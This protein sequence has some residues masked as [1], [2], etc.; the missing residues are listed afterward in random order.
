MDDGMIHNPAEVLELF[1]RYAELEGMCRRKD[2]SIAERDSRIAYLNTAL[3]AALDAPPRRM[4]NE[5]LRDSIRELHAM[6][7]R[8]QE[9]LKAAAVAATPPPMTEAD[10]A[11]VLAC[12]FAAADNNVSLEQ[13]GINLEALFECLGI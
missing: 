1:E 7:H 8:L 9:E 10:R 6:V 12:T 3:Q 11:R 4:P 5:G 2:V 13:R